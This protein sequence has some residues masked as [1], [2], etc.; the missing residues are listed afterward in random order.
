MRKEFDAQR[1][2]DRAASERRD[3][4]M[5]SMFDHV[6]RMQPQPAVDLGA[7]SSKIKQVSG[8]EPLKIVN[9]IEEYDVNDE[10]DVNDYDDDLEQTEGQDQDAEE[11]DD[12]AETGRSVFD[13]R[14]G[15]KKIEPS[16]RQKEIWAENWRVGPEYAKDDWAKTSVAKIVQAFVGHKDALA[17]KSYEP[18]PEMELR[19]PNEKAQEKVLK[20][21]EE[22]FGGIG[23]AVTSAMEV[24][25]QALEAMVTAS[26]HFLGGAKIVD[27]RQFASDTL[28]D[29]RVGDEFSY[30]Y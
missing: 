8:V 24:T 20:D 28:L 30:V 29:I 25:E 19:F 21:L 14:D 6:I 4:Q 1:K 27:A 17:F 7:G 5:Q 23:A 2:E 18:D 3:K 12:R 16:E 15:K 13:R 10:F 9:D 11:F 26:D 22:V